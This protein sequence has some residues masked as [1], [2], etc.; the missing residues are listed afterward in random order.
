MPAD[1]ETL[2]LYSQFLSR[3][4]KSTSAIK[5]YISGI[6]TMHYLLGFSVDHINDFLVNLSIRGIARLQPHCP[7]Q[8]KAITPEI[9]LKFSTLIFQTLK[10]VFFGVYFFLPSSYLQENLIW[11]LQVNQI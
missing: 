11:F 9:L 2:C 5:N 4:F 3:S 7:K 8:A 6:K 10:I 1:T